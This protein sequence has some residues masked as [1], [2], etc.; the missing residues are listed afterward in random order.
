MIMSS[1]FD[2]YCKECGRPIFIDDFIE[3]NKY[4]KKAICVCCYLNIDKQEECPHW[5]IEVNSF[6]IENSNRYKRYNEGNSTKRCLICRKEVEEN[7][8]ENTHYIQYYSSYFHGR[9]PILNK[10]FHSEI[11]LGKF[12]QSNNPDK[13]SKVVLEN[14]LRI[15]TD[16]KIVDVIKKHIKR[17]DE[18][19]EVLYINTH[20]L[21]E[22]IKNSVDLF[23]WTNINNDF[24]NIN[25][26]ATNYFKEVIKNKSTISNDDIDLF[27][28]ETSRS[29]LGHI[30]AL[31][32]LS[33]LFKERVKNK[34]NVINE[35]L[36]R[37]LINSFILSKSS[38]VIETQ[39][40]QLKNIIE[41]SDDFYYVFIKYMICKIRYKI[42]KL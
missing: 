5:A 35:F 42:R 24:N 40:L 36:D 29:N 13:V 21:K 9:S 27:F 3:Y 23:I 12:N 17:I 8:S 2:S 15:T 6:F 7:Y 39:L 38:A 10:E 22:Y 31:S 28:I 16:E 18:T 20:D 37:Y 34:N 1:K 41:V 30:M 14:L 11:N 33:L 4:D 26:I 19:N 25:S 32:Y